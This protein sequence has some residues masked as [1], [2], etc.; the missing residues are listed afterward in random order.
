M[1][2]YPDNYLRPRS[3]STRAVTAENLE[4]S[5][6]LTCLSTA[7]HAT[8]AELLR[9]LASARACF[10]KGRT[11]KHVCAQLQV[12]LDVP[13]LGVEGEQ[14]GRVTRAAPAGSKPSSVWAA[15]TERLSTASHSC[16]RPE[17]NPAAAE[18]LRRTIKDDRQ[19]RRGP[20][21]SQTRG[22]SPVCLIP[23][24]QLSQK[25]LPLDGLLQ[26][27]RLTVLSNYMYYLSTYYNCTVVL[28][29]S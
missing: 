7:R 28:R 26:V 14:L 3:T 5:W 24:A 10:E 4:T 19:A 18:A 12:R 6:W 2:T 22:L 29:R 23:T 20:K 9:Q 15:T 21:R 13:L 25:C 11:P 1:G 8:N 16:A 27:V 17:E